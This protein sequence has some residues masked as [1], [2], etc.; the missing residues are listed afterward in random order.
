LKV[1]VD[2]TV[3]STATRIASPGVV[4]SSAPRAKLVLTAGMAATGHEIVVP[5]A[6][7]TLT[8]HYVPA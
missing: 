1:V 6:A 2:L 3:A 4:A 8:A 5:T 7:P